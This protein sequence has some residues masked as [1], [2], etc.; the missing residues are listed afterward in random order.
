MQC[1]QVRVHFDNFHNYDSASQLD[2]TESKEAESIPNLKQLTFVKALFSSF[3]LYNSGRLAV[4]WYLKV[5]KPFYMYILQSGRLEL[6]R[7]SE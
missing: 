2:S 6:T 3:S 4:T 1:D 7:E 5:V